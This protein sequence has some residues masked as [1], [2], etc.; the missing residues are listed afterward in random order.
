MVISLS[1]VMQLT[2]QNLRKKRKR[3]REREK[4]K[5]NAE[6]RKA[7]N[8]FKKMIRNLHI[9]I[10]I[11]FY[12]TNFVIAINSQCRRKILINQA[13]SIDWTAR[14]FFLTAIIFLKNLK[15]PYFFNNI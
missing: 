11:F 8:Q 7:K 4:K 6:K 9:C 12:Q 15:A 14:V 10:N 13:R 3:K 1:H 5:L 2:S